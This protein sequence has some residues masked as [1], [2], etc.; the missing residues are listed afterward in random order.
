MYLFSLLS[1]VL[2]YTKIL[3]SWHFGELIKRQTR[4]K[5]TRAIGRM[6]MVI[7]VTTH[8]IIVGFTEGVSCLNKYK[9]TTQIN[10]RVIFHFENR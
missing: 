4:I 2:I 1:Y 3:W 10:E 8:L 7:S 9:S 5:T 6:S